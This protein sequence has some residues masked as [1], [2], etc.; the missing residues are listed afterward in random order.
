[1]R[2]TASCYQSAAATTAT[3]VREEL[4]TMNEI[5][6]EESPRFKE[7]WLREEPDEHGHGK[8]ERKQEGKSDKRIT[9]SK[10]QPKASTTLCTNLAD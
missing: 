2:Y 8:W 1:M 10:A 9:E 3:T 6:N 7:Y 5:I 4:L